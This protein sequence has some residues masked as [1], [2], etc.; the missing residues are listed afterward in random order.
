MGL[1]DPGPT[2]NG[3]AIVFLAHMEY[4]FT[5]RAW[6]GLPSFDVGFIMG[7][8]LEFF[9]NLNCGSGNSTPRSRLT[10]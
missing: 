6:C 3:T 10:T 2:L 4:A 9:K 7:D 1:K 8:Q 5:T